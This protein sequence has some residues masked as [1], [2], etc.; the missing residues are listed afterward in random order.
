MSAGSGPVVVHPILEHEMSFTRNS[1]ALEA[2]QL[3]LRDVFHDFFGK[4]CPPERV[5]AAEATGFDNELWRRLIGLE[6]ISMGLPESAGGAGACLVDLVIV[7]EQCGRVLAPVPFAE[8]VS[9]ARLLSRCR[10]AAADS[11]LASAVGGTRIVVQAGDSAGST[12]LV[13]A[14]AVADGVVTCHD[15][16]LV[17][18]QR[19]LH[20]DAVRPRANQASLPMAVWD[21]DAL[22][23]AECSAELGPDGDRA[24]TLV[25]DAQRERR[26]LTAATLVGLAAGALEIG[27]AFASGREA[28]GVPIGAFQA[29]SHSLV[30]AA[31]AV[32]GARHLLWKTAWMCDH[33][34]QAAQLWVLML[35]RQTAHA[36]T[37]AAA[38]SLHV[39]GGAGVVME[40]DIQLFFRRAAGWATLCGDPVADLREITAKVLAAMGRP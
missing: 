32:E 37:L 24:R 27:V 4:H 22:R 11:W 40:S 17:L 15:G 35:S 26:L 13:A 7:G 6:V 31:I 30:D 34:P 5:R 3:E 25:A 12:V 23:A 14:G 9:T 2:T 21:L 19:A 29:I 20:V 33:D 18:M 38:T 10:S 16:H 36:A 8:A 1:Y 28:F 39:H